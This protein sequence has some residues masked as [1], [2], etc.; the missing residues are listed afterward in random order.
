MEDQEYFIFERYIGRSEKSDVV[1]IKLTSNSE[2]TIENIMP[3]SLE[4]A[5]QFS[6]GSPIAILNIVD[7]DGDFINFKKYRRHFF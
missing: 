2:T 1:F 6:I 3:V 7:R 5:E 4:L